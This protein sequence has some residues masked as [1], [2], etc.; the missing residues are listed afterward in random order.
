MSTILLTVQSVNLKDK[1]SSMTKAFNVEK[2]VEVY[3][4]TNTCA[5]NALVA[6]QENDESP[7]IDTYGVAE[8]LTYINNQL[9]PDENISYEELSLSS[10]DILTLN[11]TPVE[12]IATPGAGKY[13][14]IVSAV[15]EYDYGT[16]QYIN[17]LTADLV[18]STTGTIQANAT[19]AFSGAADK[20][21][22]F[23]PV[24]GVVQADQG[25]SVKMNTGNPANG[26]GT[27]IVKVKYTIL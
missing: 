23:I 2:I 12:I 17:N 15:I 6:Y 4:N 26:N 11:G 10:A 13:I 16:I 20:V 27:A 25:I 8:T 9:N 18:T 19:N 14:S 21:T 24:A 22:R 1:T 5:G 7:M 3:A